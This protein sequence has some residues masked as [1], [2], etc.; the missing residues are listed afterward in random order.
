MVVL[1]DP[2]SPKEKDLGSFTLRWYINNTCFKKA[3]ADLG[4][5]VSVIPLTTFTNL[6]LGE[7]ASRKLT[8][9]LADKTIKHPKGIAR[10]ILVGIVVENM[11]VYHDEEIGDVIVEEPFC[12]ASCAETRSQYNISRFKGTTYRLLVPF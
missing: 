11:D 2:L 8:I 7:L 5:S 6:G 3:L 4:A 12:R 1:E 10:N 9:E